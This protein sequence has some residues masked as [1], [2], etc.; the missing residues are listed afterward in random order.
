MKKKA[1]LVLTA[2]L[3]TSCALFNR[4]NVSLS[5]S[6]SNQSTSNGSSSSSN[7]GA[8]SSYSSSQPSSSSSSSSSEDHG[9]DEWFD[10]RTKL[11]CGYYAMDLPKNH[12]NPYELRTTLAADASSWSN[13]DLKTELA[14]GFR[15]I[16]KNAC[17]DGPSGHKTSAKFYSND[18]GGLK[19]DNLGTGFQSQM[20]THTGEKLEIRIGISQLNNSSDTPQ[21]GKDT[22]HVY[23]FDKDSNYLGKYVI[24]ENTIT[25]STTEIKFYKS[26]QC[27]NTGIGYCNFKSWERA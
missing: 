15:Y 13:N 2:L 25:T 4:G 11:D 18:K 3:L 12:D 21:K 10:G 9:G 19:L 20:F 16:Y 6:T 17:D 27:Y 7:G 26:S 8:S 1:L 14:D 23:F 22:A 5:S 24:A